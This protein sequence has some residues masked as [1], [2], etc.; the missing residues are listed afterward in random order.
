MLFIMTLSFIRDGFGM[1]NEMEY[2]FSGYSSQGNLASQAFQRALR[3]GRRE[4]FLSRVWQRSCHL[5]PFETVKTKLH[6][7]CRLEKGRQEIQ[8]DQIVGSVGKPEFFTRSLMPSNGSLENRWTNIYDL[9]LGFRGY[10]PIEVYKVDEEYFI[11]DGHH[12]ASVARSLGNPT[13]EA[14]VTEWNVLPT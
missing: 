1:E 11:L 3:N 2:S 5:V 12:R 14:Y 6:L 13:I 4:A 9:M 7:I 8:L 10:P